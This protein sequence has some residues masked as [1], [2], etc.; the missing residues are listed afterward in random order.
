MEVIMINQEIESAEEFYKRGHE[1]VENVRAIYGSEDYNAYD[2]EMNSA[3]DWFTKAA[4]LGHARAMYELSCCYK[5]RQYNFDEWAHWLA[6]AAA[7]GD[8]EAQHELGEN[9]RHE[10]FNK[11]FPQDKEKAI[12]WYSQSADQDYAPAYYT[13]GRIYFT[14]DGVQKDFEK[15]N[16]WYAKAAE[17]G[18]AIAQYCLGYNYACGEGAPKD[19]EKAKHWLNLAAQSG[20]PC[21]SNAENVL[22]K[23]NAGEELKALS[24][25]SGC[26]VATCIY[27][28]YDCPE[29]WTLRRYRDVKLSASWFGRQFIGIYYAV[30]P[31]IV[32][33][34]GNKKWFHKLW[35]PILDKFVQKLQNTKTQ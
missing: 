26:Y 3:I 18:I 28:S 15:A 2:P 1:C 6:R 21:A 11:Y 23:I 16:Y 8:P 32:K 12:Y 19:L 9:Y 25:K 20:E 29:V 33:W 22:T 34:F 17:N 27:G 10:F 13:L 14:G 5:K 31:N 30:S 35:K 4:E 7:S 24:K